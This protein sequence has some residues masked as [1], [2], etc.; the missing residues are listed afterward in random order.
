MF[1]LPFVLVYFTIFVCFSAQVHSRDHWLMGSH[2]AAGLRKEDLDGSDT[3]VYVGSFVKGK[4]T[5]VGLF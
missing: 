5:L 2:F 1:R 3:S 4:Q